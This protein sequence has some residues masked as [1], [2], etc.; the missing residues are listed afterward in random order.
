MGNSKA[1]LGLEAETIATIVS[2]SLTIVSIF[3]AVTIGY[4]LYHYIFE[5]KKRK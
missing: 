4:Y 5:K 2:T 1:L 3:L